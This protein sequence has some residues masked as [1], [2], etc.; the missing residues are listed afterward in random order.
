MRLSKYVCRTLRGTLGIAVVWALA[1]CTPFSTKPTDSSKW[2][3][4]GK[5]GVT[6]PS[7]SASGFLV[8]EQNNDR[9]RIHVSGPLGQGTTEI[10]GT[11]D[12]IT[13]TQDGQVIHSN[14]PQGLIYDQLGWHFPIKNLKYWIVG[15]PSPLTPASEMERDNDERLSLLKQDDWKIEYHRYDA[16]TGLPS[17]LRISQGQWRFLLVIKHWNVG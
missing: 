16:Y 14:D 12:E 9:F 1:A 6:T 13:L 7:E 15:K 11:S 5:I 8:W 17:R 10:E 2:Q 4:Q 3:I